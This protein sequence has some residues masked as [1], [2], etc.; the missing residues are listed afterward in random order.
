VDARGGDRE[1][2]NVLLREILFPSRANA[3]WANVHKARALTL[4]ERPIFTRAMGFFTI[5]S[6]FAEEIRKALTANGI[7]C[8]PDYARIAVDPARMRV[9]TLP[10][11]QHMNYYN[12]FSIRQ[13]FERAAGLWTQTPDDVWELPG[14]E[15]RNAMVVTGEGSVF[16][17]PYRR[18]VFGRTRDDLW[19]AIQAINLAFLDGIRSA[20]VFV[21]TLG[22]TEVFRKTNDDR[23]ANQIPVYAGGGG[24]KET[25]FH[26]SGFQE[27]L[28]NLNAVIDLIARFNADARVVISVSP[29]PLERTFSGQDVVVANMQ[30]KATLRAVAGAVEKARD[31]V[32]YFPSYEI[33]TGIGVDA[34]E[35]SDLVHIRPKVV[36]SI[37][38][39]FIRSHF[40]PDQRREATG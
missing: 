6:C 10:H 39:A 32:I 23:V 38:G 40:E 36:E 20:D 26:D 33:V 5:G 3:K 16:Q 7:R 34:Y 14:R 9:D 22:M 1:L 27:N 2:G 21:I 17:D 31:N 11:R 35:P 25:Y 19:E 18:L 4:P 28:D 15:I 29:V 24:L 12:T 30:S 37:V 13:E 8:L